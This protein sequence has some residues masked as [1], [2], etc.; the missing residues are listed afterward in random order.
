M[1]NG[2]YEVALFEARVYGQ[3]EIAKG[4][5]RFAEL[6]ILGAEPPAR[7]AKYFRPP[8]VAVAFFSFEFGE[9]GLAALRTMIGLISQGEQIRRYERMIFFCLMSEVARVR[10]VLYREAKALIE[11][12]RVFIAEYDGEITM[13]KFQQTYFGAIALE[14][15]NGT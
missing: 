5:Y 10:E 11:Q 8:H 15:A 6:V 4:S 7:Q 14:R 1:N 9:T 13:E 3:P 2:K 12:R